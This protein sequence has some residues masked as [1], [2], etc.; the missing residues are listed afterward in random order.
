M[1]D[2]SY[3][4]N[5]HSLADWQE[6]IRKRRFPVYRNYTLNADDL[7]R[8]D[9][10]YSLRNYLSVDMREMERKH[11]I[12]FLEYFKPEMAALE[13][14]VGDGIVRILGGTIRATDFG[15]CLIDKICRV[16]DN[17]HTEKRHFA[18]APKR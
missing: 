13:G 5:A 6:A 4:Q 7:V 2:D 11:R 14:F 12:T 3:F 17:C 9:V 10:I 1:A 8:R 18:V 15:V 16:F